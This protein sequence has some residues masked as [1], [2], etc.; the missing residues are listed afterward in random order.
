MLR[1]DTLVM[2]F[3]ECTGESRPQRVHFAKMWNSP[4]VDR[5]HDYSSQSVDFATARFQ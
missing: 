4:R 5:G 1:R 3:A 2:E